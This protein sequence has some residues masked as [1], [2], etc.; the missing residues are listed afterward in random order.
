MAVPPPSREP[1]PLPEQP[2]EDPVLE[3]EDSDVLTDSVAPM[4][5]ETDVKNEE[6]ARSE[7]PEPDS[8]SSTATRPEEPPELNRIRSRVALW[9]ADEQQARTEAEMVSQL[10]AYRT[11]DQ[12]HVMGLDPRG[13]YIAHTLACCPTIPPPRYLLHRRNLAR[14]W[15][16]GG[17]RL[18][19][20]RGRLSSTQHRVIG[21]YTPLPD[22]EYM[23][24]P[25]TLDPDSPEHIANLIVTLP[26]ADVVRAIGR[27]RHRLDHRSTICLIN[28]GLGVAEA[29]IEAY[30]SNELT[31]PIF[32][33][34]HFTTAVGH[35]DDRFSVAEIRPGRLFLSLF[36]NE[37]RDPGQRFRIK[38]HPPPE[39]TVRATHLVRLLTAIPGLNATGHPYSDFLRYKLPLVVFRTVVDPVAALLD[40]R[41]DALAR[42]AYARQLMD[43]LVGEVAR[44]VSLLPECR[45]SEKLRQYVTSSDFREDVL[46][47]L[48]RQR[49]AD[50]RMRSLVGKGFDTDIDFLSGYFVRRGHE[51][52]APPKALDS[53][54]W[55]V[56]A[57]QRG[58]RE[59]LLNEIPFEG[60]Q[61]W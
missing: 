41:Y 43:R 59:Q 35:T 20:F 27:I 32:L 51:V 48:M 44:V 4:N 47:K 23:P 18:T 49:T 19:I 31:R 39:R 50:S 57:K 54:M 56:K 40:L 55:A 60:S 46:H 13:R 14:L 10:P 9:D 21:E 61:Q 29:L 53:V 30:F 38:R 24:E 2:R 11:S 52:G 26:P 36:S 8:S 12:L 7:Q 33:L 5:G 42:N 16:E 6:S 37:P 3:E 34:G 45:G 17:Q 1:N 28:D 22:P 58:V 15:V 25:G